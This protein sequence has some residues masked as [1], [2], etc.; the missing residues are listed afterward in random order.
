MMELFANMSKVV[1]NM[2]NE[3]KYEELKQKNR[4]S[5]EEYR[6]MAENW[7]GCIS[8]E[9]NR[10]N[11]NIS[12][13]N[14]ERVDLRDQIRELYNFLNEIGSSLDRKITIF[15]FKME[16]TKSRQYTPEVLKLDNPQ[17]SKH[18]ILEDSLF[19]HIRKHNENKKMLEKF[20]VD[21]ENQENKYLSDLMQKSRY[22][23]EIHNA[24]KIAK[25]YRNIVITVRD[26][27][28]NKII[29]EMDYIRAFMYADS[30]NEKIVDEADLNDIEPCPIIEFKGTKYD[31]HYQFVKNTFDFYEISTAFFRETVLTDIMAD[32]VVTDEE[33]REFY[34]KTSNIKKSIDSIDESKVL[35]DERD[36]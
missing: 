15:D 14:K 9:C 29:P 12:V 8:E 33:R 2:S 28:R 7:N 23:D 6:K 32:D 11:E 30:I 19:A 21:L 3:N 5:Y 1:T 10:Y 25:I 36:E 17:Y 34:E 4:E 16:E 20:E 31:K 35:K 26:A 27:I 22:F 24:V 18:R 13:I